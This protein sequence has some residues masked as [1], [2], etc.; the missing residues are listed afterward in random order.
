M[1]FY[2]VNYWVINKPNAPMISSPFDGFLYLYVGNYSKR[3]EKDTDS[4]PRMSC[5]AGN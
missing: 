3:C 4:I 5:I 1:N 2:L